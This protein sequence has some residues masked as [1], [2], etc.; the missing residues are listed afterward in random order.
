MGLNL[1]N[2]QI[3]Q[4]LDLDKDVVQDMTSQL[5]QR[6]VKGKATVKLSGDGECDEV[7]VTAG[8]KGNPHSVRKKGTKDGAIARQKAVESSSR[9]IAFSKGFGGA[10]R[11]KKKSRQFSA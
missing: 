4:E 7:Y 8:P 2:R 3:A 5:R 6:I 9:F 1:L 11:L 10:A